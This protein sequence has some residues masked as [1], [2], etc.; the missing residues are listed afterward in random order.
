MSH[1]DPAVERLIQQAV[2]Q[3]HGRYVTDPDVVRKVAAILSALPTPERGDLP[4]GDC[5]PADTSPSASRVQPGRIPTAVRKEVLEHAG[6]TC[7]YCGNGATQVDHMV[8]VS[9]GGTAAPSNLA[10][11]CRQCNFEKLDFTVAEWAEWR[12]ERGLT[13]PVNRI[14]DVWGAIAAAAEQAR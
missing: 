5:A 12:R 2:D 1:H 9:K 8:P 13:W 14:A 10:A 7:A 11:A 3:G 4:L 6:H